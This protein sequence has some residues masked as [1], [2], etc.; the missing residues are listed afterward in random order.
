MENKKMNQILPKFH[1]TIISL[2]GF[3]NKEKINEIKKQLKISQKL[4][5]DIDY[6]DFTSYV[7]LLKENNIRA[8][9]YQK[10]KKLRSN[11]KERH[12]N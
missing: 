7:Q 1:L 8:S 9:K 2:E 11:P 5:I 12:S 3:P 6:L 4:L 10:Y